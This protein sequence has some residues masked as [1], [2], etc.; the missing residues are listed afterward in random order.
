[1]AFRALRSRDF[2]LIAIGNLVSQLGFWGQYV[3]VGWEATRLTDSDFLVTVAFAAQWAPALV[4][5]PIAGVFADRYDRRKLVMFGNLFMVVPPLIIGA[6]IMSGDITMFWLVS[7]VLLCG[8][9]QSFTQPAATA[10]IPALVAAADLHSAVAL[11]AGMTNSTRVI[12]PTLGGAIIGGWGVAWAFHINA[13]S[14]F[15]VA[16][17]CHLVRVRP[18]RALTTPTSVRQELQMGFS[19]ARRNRAVARLVVL[20]VINGVWFM[21][22]ALMPIFAKR[23]LKGGASTYGLLSGAPGIGFVGAALLTTLLT[24]NRQ[25][26]GALVIGAFGLNV[27]LFTF[28]ISRNLGLSVA[29][30]GLFGFSYMIFATVITTMLIAASE[31][32]YRGRVMG[33]FVMCTMGMNPINSLLGGAVSELLGPAHT[34]VVCGIGGFVCNALFFATGGLRVIRGG[35]ER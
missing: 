1:V 22:A 25:R 28:A 9:G 15:A 17:A 18:G 10:M 21:H 13:V 14:F 4:L 20:L 3:G 8:V 11:N 30:L 23:V 6:L 7:L 33:V 29:A 35:A 34:V 27:S 32:T 26:R 24:S 19:Y 31:E 5:G 2:R 12:G 16:A